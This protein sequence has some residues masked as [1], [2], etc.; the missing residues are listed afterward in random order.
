MDEHTGASES[1]HVVRRVPVMG[2]AAADVPAVLAELEGQGV[3]AA[4]FW[5]NDLTWGEAPSPQLWVTAGEEELARVII[6]GY[7]GVRQEE[8]RQQAERA[9]DEAIARRELA[10]AVAEPVIQRAHHG[11][12][13]DRPGAGSSAGTV[14]L[15]AVGVLL[16]IVLAWWVLS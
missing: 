10:A 6:E 2:V 8:R 15:L 3:E 16:G 12:G 4:V 9:K 14:A 7:Y 13:T 11:D 1:D 5:D